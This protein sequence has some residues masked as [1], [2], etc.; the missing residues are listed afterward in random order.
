MTLV[1][2]PGGRI[3]E[4]LYK[5]VNL[6]NKVHQS[7]HVMQRY[8]TGLSLMIITLWFMYGIGFTIVGVKNALFFAI[9]CGLLEIIPFIGNLTGTVFT[10]GMA[11]IQGG[12][13]NMIIGILVVYATVQFIQTYLV[14]PL[15]VGAQVSLNAMAT[16]ISL[17]A[18]EL[19]W[20]I[21][22]LILAIPLM[23]IVK[24][25]CDHVFGLQFFALLIGDGEK[26][27]SRWTKKVNQFKKKALKLFGR[28]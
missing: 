23:G 22:G 9:L 10:L 25:I 24:I 6:L 11:L 4:L 26:K 20:G 18:G 28:K 13:T 2:L 27:D 14:E 15:I 12:S 3:R 7:A 1:R 19:L 16:I 21:P 5:L 8:L 17:V